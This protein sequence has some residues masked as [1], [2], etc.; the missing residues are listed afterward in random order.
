VVTREQLRA[1][2]E[3]ARLR[4]SRAEERDIDQVV[5]YSAQQHREDLREDRQA[6]DP[7]GFERRHLQ[8]LR[9]GHWWIAREKR[10]VVFQCHVGPQNDQVVQLGGVFTP[11][12]LRGRGYAT[13]ALAQLCSELL[14][15]RPKVCLFCDEANQAARRVYERLGFAIVGYYRSIL[16]EP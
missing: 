9:A 3:L 15:R 5:A 13:Q 11:S 12:E 4:L 1:R 8:D 2:T 16:L 10:R 7:D 14:E 6:F